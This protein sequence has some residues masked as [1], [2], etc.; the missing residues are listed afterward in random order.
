M[1]MG[2]VPVANTPMVA[3]GEVGSIIQVFP[4]PF[5]SCGQTYE[6]TVEAF[7]SEEHGGRLGPRTSPLSEPKLIEGPACPTATVEF[8]LEE[9]SVG[10]TDDGVIW[11]WEWLPPGFWPKDD[12]TLEAFGRGWLSM[13]GPDSSTR[14]GPTVEF[15]SMSMRA[16]LIG[17]GYFGPSYRKIKP[18]HTHNFESEDLAMCD[19]GPCSLGP[20]Q[21]RV[22]L[23]VHNG[24]VIEFFFRLLSKSSEVF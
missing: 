2:G 15:W 3:Q 11:E 5:P 12:H 14:D 19:P 4:V 10:E 7:I 9:L 16:D 24:D 20:G 18:N 8:I 6:Y 13:I 1:Q 23:T 22:V 21:N 17:G